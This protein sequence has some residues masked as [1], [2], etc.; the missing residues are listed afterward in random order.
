[1]PE[2]I[3]LDALVRNTAQAAPD[4]IAVIDGERQLQLCRVRRV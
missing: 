1:M 2:F 3:T 4:R